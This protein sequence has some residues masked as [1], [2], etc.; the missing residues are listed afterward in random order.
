MH[1][2]ADRW[3]VVFCAL[4]I[5]CIAASGCTSTNKSSAGAASDAL[6]FA[7][8]QQAVEQATRLLKAKD[9]ATLARYYDLEGSRLTRAELA[10]GT[11][12]YSDRVEGFQHPSGVSKY[13][14]PFAPGFTLARTEPTDRPDTLKAIMVIEIDQGGGTPQRGLSAFLI[15]KHAE[16][17]QFL[18]EKVDP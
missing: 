17:W 9:W 13:K 11:L 16:G 7:S 12:F 4:F 14:H 6:Y 10:Q 1:K 18:P 8:P 5:G 15:R 2:L 3:S